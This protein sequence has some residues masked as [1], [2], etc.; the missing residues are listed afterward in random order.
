MWDYTSCLLTRNF[1]RKNTYPNFW[2]LLS[3]CP[4]LCHC[5]CSRRTI[6]YPNSKLRPLPDSCLNHMV[7]F[8]VAYPKHSGHSDTPGRIRLHNALNI[9][10]PDRLAINPIMDFYKINFLIWGKSIRARKQQNIANH[11]Y[12]NSGFRS[13]KYKKTCEGKI[14][15]IPFS[16]HSPASSPSSV[17]SSIDLSIQDKNKSATELSKLVNNFTHYTFVYTFITRPEHNVAYWRYWPR[18]R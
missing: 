14:N 3:S 13:E 12:I 16:Y 6:W 1:R 4:Q 18:D 11:L 5:L 17:P 15:V 9:S 10:G 2:V 7:D 8:L